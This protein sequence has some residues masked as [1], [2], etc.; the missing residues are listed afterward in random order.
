MK[1]Y[2]N[3]FFRSVLVVFPFVKPENIHGTSDAVFGT[4][5]ERAAVSLWPVMTGAAFEQLS[6]I[7]EY[8]LLDTILK[9]W[10]HHGAPQQ[11]KCTQETRTLFV[12]A[13]NTID[14][15]EYLL[16]NVLRNRFLNECLPGT[17]SPHRPDQP[18]LGFTGGVLNHH[19]NEAIYDVGLKY[20]RDLIGLRTLLETTKRTTVA[21][22]KRLKNT[23][24]G[25]VD[26]ASFV[27]DRRTMATQR[28]Y[29]YS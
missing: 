22:C 4:A 9:V 13:E 7:Q 25:W 27:L 28:T 20:T 29:I 3:Q 17:C 6:V 23:E 1:S 12:D 18:H 8:I 2:Y 10:G 19:V 26:Y 5:E 16:K 11:I 21:A 24:T 15:M 14:T